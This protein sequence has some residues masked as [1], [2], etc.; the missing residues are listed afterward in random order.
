MCLQVRCLAT[1]C[2]RLIPLNGA[3]LSRHEQCQT[4]DCMLRTDASV[5]QF[6]VSWQ[7]VTKGV[8]VS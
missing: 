6:V 5:A 4:C 3:A 8:G 7:V 2:G 1:M